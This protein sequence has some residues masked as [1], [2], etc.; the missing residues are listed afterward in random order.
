MTKFG[1][2]S[3][4]RI[5]DFTQMLAG[6]FA[7]QILAD[8]G[9]DVVKV[10]SMV[11][12]ISRQGPC[13]SDDI[14]H[15][16]P[17]YFVS[18]NRN[19]RSLA[20]DLKSEDGKDIVRR[21]CKSADVVV[22]NFRSEVM[23]RL[24]LSYES[25]RSENKKL[26]YA[27]IRGFG[28]ARTL[29][30]PYQTWPAF[31]V[32][33]QAMGGVMGIT[34]PDAET[35]MKVG[36]GIGDTIP[37]IYCAFGILAA[38]HRA[39]TKGEGQYVDVA[40]TDCVLAI[41][42]RIVHQL[43]IESIVARPEGNHHPLNVPFGMFP[44]KDGWVAIAVVEDEFWYKL[45]RALDAAEL[46]ADAR[47]AKRKD[48]S[49]HR[50]LIQEAIATETSKWTKAELSEKLG[51]VVPFGPVLDAQEIATH[52]HFISR[53]MVVPVEHPGVAEPISIAGVPVKLSETPGGIKQR[54]PLLGEHTRAILTELSFDDRKI[55]SLIDRR[56]VA[57]SSP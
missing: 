33:A 44:A 17:G 14:G 13:R 36:P 31:D 54:A 50:K 26:V 20:V 18:V 55:S 35:P 10:E 9:A 51:G 39:R 34:G 11:G 48:R 29:P 22:E 8:H 30:S 12:D 57:A 15:R 56:V 38:V 53:E 5:V 16:F 41:C 32:V 40:M 28:D 23:D 19:K 43:S 6:P 47:F 42:E 24:G 45:C 1:A 46:G 52:Q 27:S 25:L 37:G 21:L 7:T 3:D 4:L 49:F 2:L